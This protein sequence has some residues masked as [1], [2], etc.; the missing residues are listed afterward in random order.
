[1]FIDASRG[2][3]SN[4]IQPTRAGLSNTNPYDSKQR[5][6]TRETLLGKYYLC[7]TPCRISSHTPE[8]GVVHIGKYGYHANWD[9]GPLQLS[10]Y[11]ILLVL[12][13]IRV[14]FAVKRF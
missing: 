1:M 13:L 4:K 2:S 12:N 9:L 3:P 11:V 10:T 5:S 14:G 8:L 7:H 6:K